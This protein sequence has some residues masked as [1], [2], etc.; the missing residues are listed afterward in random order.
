MKDCTP[1]SIVM[2][3]FF[4]VMQLFVEKTYRHYY[5]YLEMLDEGHTPLSDVTRH[6]MYLILY[7]IMQMGQD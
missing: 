3:V 7:L 5:Q 2:L 1:L 6:E 4:K